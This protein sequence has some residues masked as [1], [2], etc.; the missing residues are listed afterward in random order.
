[1]GRIVKQISPTTTRYY[2]YPGDRREWARAGIAFG[3]GAAAFTVLGVLTKDVLT[4]TVVGTSATAGVAGVNFGRRDAR[5]LAGFPDLADKAA[6]RAAVVH[7]G[8]A[9]WRGVAEGV[10][11]AS[12]AVLI[13]NLPDRGVAAHWLLP[14]V[15]AVVGA[16]AHQGG[17]LWEQ[18]GRVSAPA[19]LP[20]YRTAGRTVR[21]RPV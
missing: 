18:T 13:A 19:K 12:A 15:P 6:R 1:M 3:V 21:E 20:E 16:L 17:M 9:A 14:L 7:T 8:R 4:A 5:A 10:G 2:W 11:G